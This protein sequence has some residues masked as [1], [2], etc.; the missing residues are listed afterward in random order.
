MKKNKK[1]SNLLSK[2]LKVVIVNPPTKEEAKQMIQKISMNINNL[3]LQ[4]LN[5]LEEIK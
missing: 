3:Y 5:Q 2:S 4:E 1:S